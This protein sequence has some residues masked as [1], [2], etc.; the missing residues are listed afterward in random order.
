[1]AFDRPS[2]RGST[3]RVPRALTR[4]VP[5]SLASCELTHL[6]RVPIDLALAR[7][8][9]A[10]YEHA[11]T[12]MGCLVES[13]SAAMDMPD[14]VFIEDT[15]V[16]FDEIAVIARSGAAP[17]RGETD[18]V[19]AALG[20]YRRLAAICAPATL[21]GGDVL[22]VDRD[23]YVGISGRTNAAAATQLTE[24]LA[25]Y[26]YRVHTVQTRGCLH[27]KSAATCAGDDLIICNPE[28]V[29]PRHFVGLKR[30]EIDPS[31]PAAANV[32]RIGDGLLCSAAAPKTR[33]RLENR[34]L[35]V[36]VVD[37]SELAKAEGALTCCS[38]ILA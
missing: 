26:R 11:L 32:V 12:Q 8:Q 14:S 9:H 4:P 13:V 34:G 20:R 27:L 19:A 28:W 2:G 15:A 3:T 6:E 17:R 35:H 31:E 18:A 36:R 5:N 37:V 25:P 16:V 38:L 7:K 29:D 21:D 30:M 24:L 33:A 22:R 10:A 1:V 23:V